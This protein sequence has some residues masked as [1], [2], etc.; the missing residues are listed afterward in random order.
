MMPVNGGSAS[1]RR[2]V[3]VVDIDDKRGMVREGYCREWNWRAAS[4][5]WRL[6]YAMN[7]GMETI[8]SRRCR[9]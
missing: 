7:T 8:R 2:V 5:A 9:R 4:K 6:V 1:N 3:V